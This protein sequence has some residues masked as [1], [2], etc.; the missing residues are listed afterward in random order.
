ME[1]SEGGEGPG[2]PESVDVL[3]PQCKLCENCMTA[4]Y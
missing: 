4:I 3:S 2:E 1:D